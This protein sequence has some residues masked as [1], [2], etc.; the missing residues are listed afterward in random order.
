MLRFGGP[1]FLG[2]QD[3]AA[4]AGESHGAIVEDPYALA[5][6]HKRKGWTAAF[7]PKIGLEDKE[8]IRGVRDAFQKEDI[9]IAEVGC[10]NNILDTDPETRKACR[11]EYVNALAL[12][13]ELGAN[14]VVGLAG[15]YCHGFPTTHAAYNFSPESF[16]ETVDFARYCIDTVKPKNTHFTYEVYQFNVVDSV[17][18][19][20]KLIKAIDRD[21]FG[22]HLDLTNF[23][24]SPRTYWS[25]GDIMHECIKAFGDKIVAAH[26][27]DAKMKDGVVS[28]II[29]EVIPGRG[30]VDIATMVRELHRLPQIVPYM[31]EH[32][33]TEEEYDIAATHIRQVALGEGIVL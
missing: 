8:L 5:L 18:N 33:H 9:I 6:A 17:E 26:A 21:R 27:K 12:A 11:E 16:A 30:V 25:T 28:V 3:K 23:T 22:V 1:V 32:L 24:N 10:W 4:G 29:D 31:M 19:I 14:C 7:A 20:V 13:E 15:G 2:Q